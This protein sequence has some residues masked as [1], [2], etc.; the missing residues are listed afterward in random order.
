M[1]EDCPECFKGVQLRNGVKYRNLNKHY[2]T[3]VE[4]LWVC[5]KIRSYSNNGFRIIK[6]RYNIKKL[7]LI[8]WL[9]QYRLEALIDPEYGITMKDLRSLQT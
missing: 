8:Y 1:F 3:F 5:E 6:L 9:R 4:K 7:Y 2:F